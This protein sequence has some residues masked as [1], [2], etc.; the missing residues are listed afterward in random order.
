MTEE[1]GGAETSSKMGG[2]AAA[3]ALEELQLMKAHTLVGIA[4]TQRPDCIERAPVIRLSPSFK[5]ISCDALCVS[6]TTTPRLYAAYR[7]VEEL[8][9]KTAGATHKLLLL[10]NKQASIIASR[11]ESLQTLLNALEVP[12]PSLVIN[13]LTSP[14]FTESLTKNLKKWK[15]G[16][17]GQNTGAVHGRGPF[18]SKAD[19]DEAIQQLETFMTDVLIPLAERTNA[20]VM[21]NA[22]PQDCILARTLLRAVSVRRARWRGN[23]P[24]SILSI[25]ADALSQ[26]YLNKHE[27]AYW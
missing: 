5:R 16:K 20:V 9:G 14:G 24:F 26:L 1:G 2:S 13:L 19:E 4:T 6:S 10:T 21:C 7:M 8:P 27:D 15:G 25:S 12:K 23:P 11:P 22:H 18:A 3:D 17:D